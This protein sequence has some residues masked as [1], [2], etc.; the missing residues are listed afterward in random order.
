MQDDLVRRSVVT[1]P[2]SDASAFG[3]YNKDLLEA[4]G[5][6]YPPAFKHT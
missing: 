1:S 4:K 3:S 5:L 2:P 6:D